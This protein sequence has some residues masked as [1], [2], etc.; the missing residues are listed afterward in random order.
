MT[1]RS[2]FAVL[3]FSLVLASVAGCSAQG[4]DPEENAA[5]PAAADTPNVGAVAE[6]LVASPLE[7]SFTGCSELASITTVSVAAART[8]VPR[9]FTLAGDAS[10]APFVVRVADCSAVRIDGGPPEAGT[11]AQLGVSVVSPDGT[12][13]INNYTAWYYTTSARLASRLR[14]RGVPAEYVPRLVYDVA[15][16]DD[17]AVRALTVDVARPGHPPFHVTAP[18]IEPGPGAI[19][20]HANWWKESGARRTKMSTPIPSIRFG[21]ATATLQ[22]R[23]FGELG[24]LLGSGTATFALLDS[25]NRF[26]A[27]PMTVTVAHR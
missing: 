27:A 3:S 14:A 16:S 25:F 1:H 18:V 26:D 4:L 12:G 7:V 13:D 24:R 19:P 23:R 10:G 17:P 8:I 9:S 20:F 6:E 15:S 11:V 2:S 22:T 5:S 21:G